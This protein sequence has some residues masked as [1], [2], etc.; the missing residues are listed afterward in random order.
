M[1]YSI[2]YELLDIGMRQLK[3]LVLRFLYYMY[4]YLDQ[5]LHSNELYRFTCYVREADGHVKLS[6]LKIPLLGQS[7]H[8]W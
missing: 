1:S 6:P 5:I 7:S 3:A 8:L 4:L 2:R